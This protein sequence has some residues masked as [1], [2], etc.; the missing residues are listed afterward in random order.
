MLLSIEIDRGEFER[1][2]EILDELTKLGFTVTNVEKLEEKS[3]YYLNVVRED[4]KIVLLSKNLSGLIEVVNGIKEKYK[5]K[6]KI[7]L[8]PNII[9]ENKTAIM[10]YMDDKVEFYS[11]AINGT[12]YRLYQKILLK[13]HFINKSDEL[14]K[15]EKTGEALFVIKFFDI[16]GNLYITLSPKSIGKIETIIISP[17]E[18]YIEHVEIEASVL[19]RPGLYTLI[20]ETPKIFIGNREFIYRTHPIEVKVTSMKGFINF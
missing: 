3:I 13:T 15:M 9:V 12:S 14:M 17:G 5:D 19:R 6:V 16:N 18:E 11:F 10:S 20:I 2:E 8:V 4:Q 7:F 1:D